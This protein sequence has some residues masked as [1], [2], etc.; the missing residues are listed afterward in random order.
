MKQLAN[1]TTEG[2]AVQV[3]SSDRRLICSLDPSHG[4]AFLLGLL[5]G[6]VPVLI[7]IN[8]SSQATP[9]PAVSMPAEPPFGID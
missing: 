3:Y 1:K 2:W 6:I 9:R 7:G 4:W 5:L 8:A